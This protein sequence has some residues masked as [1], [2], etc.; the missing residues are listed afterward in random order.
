LVG[1]QV[2]FRIDYVTA[3]SG[4]EYGTVFVADENITESLVFAGWAQ[5]KPRQNISEEYV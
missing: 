5:V 2:G 4:K 1:K 3:A